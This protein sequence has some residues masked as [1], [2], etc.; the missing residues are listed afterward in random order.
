MRSIPHLTPTL[1]TRGTPAQT[2]RKVPAPMYLQHQQEQQK[3]QLQKE[4]LNGAVCSPLADAS[5]STCDRGSV[6]AIR[7]H[8]GSDEALPLSLVDAPG[9]T[10]TLQ[11]TIPSCKTTSDVTP[12]QSAYKEPSD[13]RVHKKV[14]WWIY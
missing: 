7:P 8:T 12:R 2:G 1:E 14:S 5:N 3:K 13:R 10:E 6:D 9:A 11:V 4:C